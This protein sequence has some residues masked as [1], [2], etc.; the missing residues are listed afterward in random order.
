MFLVLISL[1]SLSNLLGILKAAKRRKLSEKAQEVDDLKKRL[2]IIQD[3]DDDVFVEATPL[4]QKV[5][6]VDYQFLT[7]EK[8]DEEI[9][10]GINETPTQKAAKRRRLRKQAIEDE[11]LKKQ[12]EVVVD[13][14]DD[15]FIEATSIGRKVPVVNY[16]IVMINNKPR[17]TRWFME[18]STD[19]IW[20][21][22]EISTFQVHS[23]A[24][25]ECGKIESGRRELDV[26]RATQIYKTAT[27]RISTRMMVEHVKVK[28]A[29]VIL[30]LPG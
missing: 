7:M 27:L 5:P 26:V 11:D 24:V 15:V 2:E 13:E 1:P 25:D 19:C 20:S 28:T 17:W 22:I 14:D 9:I 29:R 30:M 16:D 4:A 18:K 6:V 21:S 12:L 23:G 8:E 10:K 3:E